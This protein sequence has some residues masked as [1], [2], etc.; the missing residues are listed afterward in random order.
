MQK[1]WVIQLCLSAMK[2]KGEEKMGKKSSQ[3]FF[4]KV[5]TNIPYQDTSKMTNKYPLQTNLFWISMQKFLMQTNI[6]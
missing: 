2:G 4:Y 6:N 3:F 5:S 1:Y